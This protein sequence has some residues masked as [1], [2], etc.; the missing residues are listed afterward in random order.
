LQKRLATRD[1]N[2]IIAEFQ[3]SAYDGSKF[4][5]FTLRKSMRRIAVDASEMAS[6]QPDEH[7][8]QPREC[9][10]A[11][12]APVDFVDEQG[13][14]GFALKRLQSVCMRDR[15]RLRTATGRISGQDRKR[16]GFCVSTRMQNSRH[17]LSRLN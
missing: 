2:Q 9:A 16:V 8:R 11:L 17:H 7:A 1:L 3:R 14:S 15:L 13:A 5:D 6:R 12:Q 4:D 10:L